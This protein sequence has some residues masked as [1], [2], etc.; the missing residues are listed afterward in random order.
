MAINGVD[1]HYDASYN[2]SLA[3]EWRRMA[4]NVPATGATLEIAASSWLVNG[5]PGCATALPATGAGETCDRTTPG[6]LPMPAA[7]GG[8]SIYVQHLNLVG[9][10]SSVFKLYDRLW[11]CSGLDAT[12][13]S[14]TEQVIN[15]VA[16]P[17]RGGVGE[18]VMPFVEVYAVTGTPAAVNVTLRYK[19]T[20]DVENSATT[21][22]VAM[23]TVGRFIPLLLAAGDRGVR[24]PLGVTLSAAPGG[25][26]NW[27][28]T[29]CRYI[30]MNPTAGT[31]WAG[32]PRNA[33]DQGGPKLDDNACLFVAGLFGAASTS[34]TAHGGVTLVRG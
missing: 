5:A 19:N 29:L 11:Q 3:Y 21:T 15:G 12:T 16:L 20:L 23:T 22:G 13:V 7:A 14:P 28:I 10:S 8:E 25:T 32:E 9:V 4:W 26:V 24:R 6:A 17:A 2:A 27:G 18:L 30:L 31:S 34:T 33:L 1:D